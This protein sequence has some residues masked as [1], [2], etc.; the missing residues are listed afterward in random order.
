MKIKKLEDIVFTPIDNVKKYLLSFDNLPF[1][2]FN[3]VRKILHFIKYG[4]ASL[5]LH[6]YVFLINF[7]VIVSYLLKH[8]LFI[9]FLAFLFFQ[10]EKLSYKL[11]F[12][13]SALIFLYYS[14]LIIIGIITKINDVIFKENT[15]ELSFNS[16]NNSK[17]D[18]IIVGFLLF[19]LSFVF[20]LRSISHFDR[21]ILLQPNISL[22]TFI[23]FSIQI[24]LNAIF[25]DFISTFIGEKKI[26]IEQIPLYLKV[27]LYLYKVLG[28]SALIV[29]IFDFIGIKMKDV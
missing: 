26:F 14:I 11:T 10:I 20:L 2:N 15:F 4:V 3:I 25:L 12:S 21:T 6:S 5:V 29:W 9:I 1:D 27:L 22:N 13:I 7:I 16:K 19:T 18:L 28:T 8:S 17:N 23:V 24:P